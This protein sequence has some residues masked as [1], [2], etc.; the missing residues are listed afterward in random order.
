MTKDER[1]RLRLS[2]LDLS[3]YA[4]VMPAHET[5]HQ[6][7]GDMVMWRGYRDLWLSEALANYSALLMIESDVPQNFRTLMDYYRDSLL[8][9]FSLPR[10]ALGPL[11]LRL[12]FWFRRLG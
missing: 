11:F 4:R 9:N 6:W 8:E 2:P 7:W 12:F 1:V 10:D 5:A 3:F